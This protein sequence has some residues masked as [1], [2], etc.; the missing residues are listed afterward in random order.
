[1]S[2]VSDFSLVQCTRSK[3]DLLNH[4]NVVGFNSC[5][6]MGTSDNARISSFIQILRKILGTI[7]MKTKQLSRF[8]KLIDR[9]CVVF[10]KTKQVVLC[11]V[12][13]L[14]IF[15]PDPTDFTF[16]I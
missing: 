12:T 16:V 2:C 8:L 1:M 7:F 4:T 10:K 5:D 15:I 11:S 9:E 14:N 6:V 3:A 13:G